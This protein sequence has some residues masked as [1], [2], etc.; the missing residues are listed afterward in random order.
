M[1]A[2]TE[3]EIWREEWQ[4]E[5]SIPADLQRKVDRQS[6]QMRIALLADIVVT[7]VMGSGWTAWALLSKDSGLAV[8]AVAVWIFLVAAWI[9]VLRVNRGLWRPSAMDAATFVDLSVRRCEGALKAVWFAGILF[10]AEIAFDLSWIYVRLDMRQSWWRWLLFGSVRTDIV[11]IG[12]VVFF[13]GL[14]WYRA[15]KRLEL[16]RLLQMRE[17]ILGVG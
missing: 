4:S 11:W 10:V 12:T 16:D 13:S 5:A 14:V 1:N 17:E 3:L 6:R 7:V 9:F 8:V 15:R 2:D